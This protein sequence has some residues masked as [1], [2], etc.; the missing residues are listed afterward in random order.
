MNAGTEIGSTI[1]ASDL[2]IKKIDES[3]MLSVELR[4]PDRL[5]QGLDNISKVAFGRRHPYPHLLFRD[6]LISTRGAQILVRLTINCRQG[7]SPC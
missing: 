6:Q 7:D 5:N 1:L 3:K 2:V 4:P